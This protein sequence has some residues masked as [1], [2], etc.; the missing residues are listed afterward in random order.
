MIS[1]MYAKGCALLATVVASLALAGGAQADIVSSMT[2]ELQAA[3][4]PNVSVSQS[5][6]AAATATDVASFDQDPSGSYPS[7]TNQNILSP[8]PTSPLP[9][10]TVAFGL[11][12]VTPWP[13]ILLAPGVAGYPAVEDS[14]VPIWR[15]YTM[16]ALKHTMIAGAPAVAAAAMQPQSPNQ[17]D[18]TSADLYLTPPD[19]SEY[20]TQALA[21]TMSLSAVQSG[22]QSALPPQFQTATVN[23]I[24]FAGG[25]RR[26]LVQASLAPQASELTPPSQLYAAVLSA[27][28]QLDGQGGNVGPVIV[29]LTDPTTN[30]PLATYAGDASWGQNFSWVAPSATPFIDAWP[31]PA[32]EA[33]S[34]EVSGYQQHAQDLIDGASQGQ[35]PGQ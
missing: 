3:G 14:Q 33:P 7:V 31:G 6:P 9:I 20:P 1:T 16:E 23:V 34:D 11:V 22:I 17:P 12:H 18:T 26:V 13:G 29:S 30:M 10:V 35:L 19:S 4:V 21:Q 15:L 28:T 8:D 5:T 32:P 24:D 25:Q 2:A 27:Q